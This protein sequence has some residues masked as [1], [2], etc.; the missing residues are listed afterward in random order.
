MNRLLIV[1]RLELQELPVFTTQQLA[2]LLGM[3]VNSTAVLLS[4]LVRDGVLARVQRGRYCLPST[5]LLAVASG[6]YTPSYVSLWAAFEYY[7][8]TTQSP[9]VIDV[10]NLAH[11]GRVSLTL[12]GESFILRFIKTTGSLI[13]G[14]NKTYVGNKVAFLAE[15]ERAII[16]GLLFTGY[17]PL[18]E[19]VEAVRSGIDVNKAIEYAKRTKKQSVMKRLGYL[20]TM[21]GIIFSPHDFGKLSGTYVPLDPSLPKRGRY[22]RLWRVID[23][24]VIK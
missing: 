10:I 7:G 22:D 21:E 13:Y 24:T 20:L 6:I 11:S 3:N 8:I 19:V 14:L 17:V 12:E 5:N 1:K 16:D 9:R 15:K 2:V 18:D 23:N 4:R